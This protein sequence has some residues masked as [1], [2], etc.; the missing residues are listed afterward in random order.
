MNAVKINERLTVAGQ[1][2]IADFPSLSA[3]GYK[4]II[5]PGPVGDDPGPPAKPP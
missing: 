5:T 4:S 2:M 3:Q 1:P